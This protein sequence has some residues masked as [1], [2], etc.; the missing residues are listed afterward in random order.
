M[1]ACVRVFEF[2]VGWRVRV[3][4]LFVSGLLVLVHVACLL[5]CVSLSLS[6][7]LCACVP[8]C[9]YGNVVSI[10]PHPPKG[11]AVDRSVCLVNELEQHSSA[12]LTSA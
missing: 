9:L 8:L 3:L 6:L 12:S 1:I 10:P 4:G 5:V 11:L 2:F 7:S